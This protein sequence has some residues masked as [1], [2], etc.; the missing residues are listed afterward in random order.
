MIVLMEK[1]VLE[2]KMV[3]KECSGVEM[4]LNEDKMSG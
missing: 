1:L 3:V 2:V 4:N